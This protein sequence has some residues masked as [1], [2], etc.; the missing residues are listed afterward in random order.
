MPFIL[1]Q[2]YKILSHLNRSLIRNHQLQQ[3]YGAYYQ[4][5]LDPTQQPTIPV[6]TETDI[7]ARLDALEAK[8]EF[9]VDS[10]LGVLAQL[11]TTEKNLRDE[12]GSS[13]FA[14]TKADKLEWEISLRTTGMEQNRDELL[15][16]LR[17]YLGLPIAPPE[18]TGGTLGRS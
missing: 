16:E 12:K 3:E 5:T 11:D 15:Q 17:Y 18:K 14:I 7:W 1:E 9:L 10:V 8:S 4:L 13:N 6:F 2:R